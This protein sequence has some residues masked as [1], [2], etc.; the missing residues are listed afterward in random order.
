MNKINI[1]KKFIAICTIFT[2][3]ISFNISTKV[4]AEF[5]QNDNDGVVYD[6]FE[7]F[8][9]VDEK[10]IVNCSLSEGNGSV[11]LEYSP[12]N[13]TYNHKD[14]PNT[15]DGWYKP[16]VI[17][18]PGGN[19]IRHLSLLI[20]PESL[21]A[22]SMDN[23]GN[24]DEEYEFDNKFVE[25]ISSVKRSWGI[26]YHQF[27]LFKIKIKEDPSELETFM[28]KWLPGP[29]DSEAYLDEIKIFLW[30]FGDYLPTWSNI[31]NINYNKE[32]I[33]NYKRT[34]TKNAQDYISEDG[35][36]YLLVVG[37][38]DS[39][40][41]GI[42]YTKLTTDFLSVVLV[43]EER[44][45]PD[46]YIISKTIDT[47][48]SDFF[49]WESIMWESSVPTKDTYVKIQVL[50][51]NNSIINS[52]DGNS[53]GFKNSPIDLSTLG[54]QYRKIRLKA[55][56]H[57]E[58]IRKTP[59]LLSWVVLWHTSKG[60]YDS[61]NFSFRVGES[62]GIKLSSGNV[63]ISKYY[64]NWPMYGKNPS[65][66]RSYDG[67]KV[68]IK[69]NKSYWQTDI[70]RHIAGWF[71]SPVVDDGRVY[72]GADDNK[73]YAFDLLLDQDDVW[74][75]HSPVDQSNSN[76]KIETGVAVDDEY[77]VF[78][79]SKLNSNENK[80][81]A[82]NKNNLKQEIW[83]YPSVND[84]KICFSASPTISDGVVYITSWSGVSANNNFISDWLDGWNNKALNFLGS[85]LYNNRLFALDIKTG[86]TI[87]APKNLP[88]ASL[89][90]PAV[91]DGKIFIGL[92]RLDGPSL[93]AYDQFTGEKVWNKTVGAIGR[94]SPIVVDGEDGKIVIALVREQKNF[95]TFNGTDKIVA[96]DADDGSI[97]WNYTIGNQSTLLR[98]TAFLFSEYSNLR[99]TISPAATPA[100]Y[101]DTVYVLGSDGILFAFD[102][103]SGELKWKYDERKSITFNS[104][105][106]IVVDDIVYLL[107]RNCD[108]DL[109]KANN[110]ERISSHR[111]AYGPVQD[112]TH[113]LFASPIIVDGL[114]VASIM[115]LL[116]LES[117][118]HLICFGDHEENK[119]GKINSIPIHLQKGT[120]WDTFNAKTDKTSDKN[121][122]TFNI[123]DEDGNTLISNLN[124]SNNNISKIQKNVIHLS[125]DL[126]IED[127]E[128]S[129]PI[130]RSW[131]INWNIEDEPPIFNS[132]TFR[133]GKGQGGWINL[134]LSTCTIDVKDFGVGSVLSGID[135]DTAKFE[136][137][138]V[139]NSGN[140]I[141]KTF[142]A[143]CDGESGDQQVTVIANISSLNLKIKDFKNITFQIKDLAGNE[144]TSEKVTFKLDTQKPKSY[145]KDADKLNNTHNKEVII[146]AGA[147]NDKSGIAS[148]ALY[149]K[150]QEESDW[151]QYGSD[152]SPYNW[153]FKTNKSGIYEFTTVAT[154]N[155][156]NTEDIPNIGD[157]SFLFDMN[158]PSKPE[159]DGE[160]YFNSKPEFSGDKSV[161]F[162]DDYEIEIIE[163]RL[164]FHGLNDWTTIIYLPLD[165]NY[166]EAWSLSQDDWDSMTEDKKYYIYFRVTDTAG[167]I[168]ETNDESDALVI[169]KDI[170][171]PVADVSFDIGEY[172]DS[173]DDTFTITVFISDNAE[174]DYV[175]LEYSYST[176]EK[177]WSEWE[178]YGEELED[179]PFTWTFEA[180]DGSGYYKFKTKLYDNAGNYIES[181]EEMVKVTE[182][183]ANSLTMMAILFVI[184]FLISI[185]AIVKMKK[186]KE[187]I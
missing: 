41:Y 150:L 155:A 45:L 151:K 5:I 78:G 94:A 100:Y 115:D 126:K 28:I 80:I 144:A 101:K 147:E 12:D 148:I 168:Y 171:P 65:N 113:F 25:T 153:S 93:F 134:D 62:N 105:S 57:S 169:I 96:L 166:T 30:A 145:I 2:L 56:L 3:I 27:H 161:T 75:K 114:I 179:S 87:W 182:F 32:N 58:K 14:K 139:D 22:E 8:E 142:D 81:Y 143:E 111:I 47:T 185:F 160:Y 43:Y 69:S 104:A 1:A 137:V 51:E 165:K 141:T 132:G 31:E 103:N 118:G 18:T 59:Y 63:E 70:N 77:I 66:T 183:P 37:K 79:T 112:Y 159:F 163:Y 107:T 149:Y 55:I 98:K 6:T 133:A 68:T 72:V 138:Y 29:Y 119:D 178:E 91:D 158:S 164:D 129:Y 53:D 48:K 88:S 116:G 9:S 7:N 44:Y 84:N 124:G 175:I 24:I 131:G 146:S 154:D 110:G 140:T 86:S 120:W 73:I 162:K 156:G 184:L 36:I 187:Q 106:P 152:K 125:A 46:G 130:L 67:K 90:A 109:L 128:N 26:T 54:S 20:N 71:K 4:N 117:Y 121:N 23:L 13:V 82:L 52:I 108:L 136:L 157:V 135:K 61:F 83:R 11:I 38:P 35:E 95:L 122:I 176:D 40:I 97:I 49:G 186:K 89:N 170:S 74:Y 39:Q 173:W 33:D 92:D 180:P 21:E 177:K 64:N 34:H 42:N 167:N 10:Q 172:E 16:N 19:I 50:D 76:F 15:I 181:S 102:V 174:F 85:R 17:L 127:T 60:F 123:L 99:G